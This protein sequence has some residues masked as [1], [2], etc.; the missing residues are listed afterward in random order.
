MKQI[1]AVIRPN[2]LERVE[3]ALY[4]L[5]HFPGITL[6]R[7]KGQS[8]GRAPGYRYQ[9]TEWD[10]EDHDREMLLTVCADEFA[11]QVVQTIREAAHT[12]LPGDGLIVVSEVSEVVRIRSHEHGESAV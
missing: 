2:M 9:A 5:E 1:V 3:H 4:A 10:I 6:L 8:R 11:P 12:G 7:V